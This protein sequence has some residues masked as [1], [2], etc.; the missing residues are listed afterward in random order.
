MVFIDNEHCSLYKRER[1][2]T[3]QVTGQGRIQLTHSLNLVLEDDQIWNG[4]TLRMA[5]QA[6][7][8]T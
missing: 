5:S 8:V 6:K 1:L 7:L 4:I 2:V 3:G